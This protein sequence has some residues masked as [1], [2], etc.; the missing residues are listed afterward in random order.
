MIPEPAISFF[1][2]TRNFRGQVMGERKP[3]GLRV[4]PPGEEAATLGIQ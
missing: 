3:P 2:S 4:A 1:R